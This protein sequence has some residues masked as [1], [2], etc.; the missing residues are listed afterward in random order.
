MS[1]LERSIGEELP[2]G[3]RYLGLANVTLAVFVLD[4]ALT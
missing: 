4:S 2:A 3:E 1:H